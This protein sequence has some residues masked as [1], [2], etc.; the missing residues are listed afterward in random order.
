MVAFW[1]EAHDEGGLAWDDSNNNRAF[2]SGTCSATLNGASIYI[3]A[4]RKPDTY[5]TRGQAANCRTASCS[6]LPKGPGGQFSYHR[7][8]PTS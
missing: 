2:L 5:K 1:K 6:P 4:K 7:P 8:F 3:E